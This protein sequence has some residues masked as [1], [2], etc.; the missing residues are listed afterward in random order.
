MRFGSVASLVLVALIAGA[1][2]A[3]A[4]SGSSSGRVRTP[5][6]VV[7]APTPSRPFVSPARLAIACA[8]PVPVPVTPGA[9]TQTPQP[10]DAEGRH[11][12][13]ALAAAARRLRDPAPPA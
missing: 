8:A 9:K 4:D 12:A 10:Q 5:V 3:H 6:R 7:A 11:V 13:C 2:A 1:I